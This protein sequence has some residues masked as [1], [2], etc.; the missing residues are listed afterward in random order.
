MGSRGR[1]L[2]CC[3]MT[4]LACLGAPK[5]IW[6]LS[7]FAPLIY[8]SF[9]AVWDWGS[10]I[11]MSMHFKPSEAYMLLKTASC[12]AGPGTTHI[13]TFDLI[14]DRCVFHN[15]T[16][17]HWNYEVFKLILTS[18]KPSSLKQFLVS[19]SIK[20]IPSR[21]WTLNLTISISSL[22]QGI[23]LIFKSTST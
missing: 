5:Y 19:L 7:S 1:I 10:W 23:L 14:A 6:L 12:E 22:N 2:S 8:Y 18:F 9:A 15:S 17:V 3:N 13:C 20:S 11:F 21:D 16:F 4:G